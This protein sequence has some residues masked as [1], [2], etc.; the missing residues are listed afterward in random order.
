MH[1]YLKSK[2]NTIGEN[3]MTTITQLSAKAP[4]AAKHPEV[5]LLLCCACTYVDTAIAERITTLLQEDIDWTYLL[6]TAARHGITP[7]LYW[8]LNA[9]CP[10]AVPKSILAQLRDYFHINARQNLFLS[11]E[12]LKLLNLFQTHGISAIPFKGPVLA[13]LAYGNL[14]LRQCSDLDILV[15]E[16]EFLKT[17]DLL[18]SQEYQPQVEMSWE[19]HFMHRDGRVI[20]DLHQAITPRF[21]PI[22]F[23]FERLWKHLEPISFAGTT[24]FTFLPEDLLLILCVKLVKDCLQGTAR[25]AQIC[26]IAELV[27][28]YQGM[29]WERV[30]KEACTLGSKRMLFLGLLLAKELLGTAF[31]EKIL[32]SIQADPVLKAIALKLRTWLFQKHARSHVS[33][34]SV[35]YK[36]IKRGIVYLKARERLQER[37]LYFLHWACLLI[38]PTEDDRK[39]LQLPASLSFLYYLIRPPRLVRKY[40]LVLLRRFSEI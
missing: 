6:Q 40:A 3:F 31:P 24:V 4:T 13:A 10:E 37:V 29:D 21:F 28:V 16:R 7:L 17:K 33:F 2:R 18:L 22:A 27:R 25:L 15:S 23:D 14:S 20:V 38:I 39:L 32:Q 19:A 8:N 35:V 34:E 30:I 1:T 9:T 36:D 26:D 12:L 11:A 5:E